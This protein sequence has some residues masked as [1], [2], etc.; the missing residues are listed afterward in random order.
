MSATDELRRM[1]DER[2]VEYSAREDSWGKE[3]YW[4]VDHCPYRFSERGEYGSCVLHNLTP[5]Q[6]IA[7]TLGNSRAE[8]SGCECEM[9]RYRNVLGPID[10]WQCSKCEADVKGLADD[11][12]PKFCPNCGAKVIE[13][14]E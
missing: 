8:A 1:L 9:R 2:G 13:E 4:I 11:T 10:E 7:A 12:P 14:E 5:E 3:T 6:A